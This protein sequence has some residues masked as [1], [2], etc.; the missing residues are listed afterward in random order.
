MA[1]LRFSPK[2]P[3]LTLETK[4]YGRRN[5]VTAVLVLDTGS[6]FSMISTEIAEFLGLTV[7]P[8]RTV[9]IL[10]VSRSENIPLVIV[11]KIS[12]LDLEVEDVACL[13][14]DLPDAE[15]GRGLLGLS[16]LKNLELKINFRRGILEIN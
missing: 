1:V 14:K 2:A 9:E 8:R 4:I 10:T 15:S 7:N 12:F 11:P 5:F 6:T 3:L 16:F 13:V